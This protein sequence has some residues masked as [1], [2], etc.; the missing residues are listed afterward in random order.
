MLEGIS[1][2]QQY[3]F[4]IIFKI[5][6][7]IKFTKFRNTWSSRNICFFIIQ[8]KFKWNQY[9]CEAMLVHVFKVPVWYRKSPSNAWC[10]KIQ[11]LLFSLW[12]YDFETCCYIK[13]KLP[14]FLSYG[15]EIVEN[16]ITPVLTEKLPAPLALIELSACS[17]KAGWEWLVTNYCTDFMYRPV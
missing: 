15:W 13:A 6:W 5:R 12:Y 7:K 14:S 4:A 11:N 10:F 8:R 3:Y 17:C 9:I 16:D 1:W 2:F